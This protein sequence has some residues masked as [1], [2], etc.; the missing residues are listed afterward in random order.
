MAI[1]P[2]GKVEASDASV[3][4]RDVEGSLTR[5]GEAWRVRVGA[6]SRLEVA[7][8]ANERHPVAPT[9]AGW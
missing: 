8:F 7:R 4:A 6:S 3:E 9:F 5:Q 1:A 2:I